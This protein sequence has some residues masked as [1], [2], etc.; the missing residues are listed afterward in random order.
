MKHYRIIISTIRY[1][2]YSGI[3]FSLLYS[4]FTLKLKQNLLTYSYRESI[5]K[6][7]MQS[8]PSYYNRL[9]YNTFI[10]L[11]IYNMIYCTTCMP[12]TQ[13]YS[14]VS[15]F[16]RTL[17]P[18]TEWKIKINFR[19]FSKRQ[20]NLNILN[21]IF[22]LNYFKTSSLV[23]RFFLIF[24]YFEFYYFVLNNKMWRVSRIKIKHIIITCTFGFNAYCT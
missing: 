16:N 8:P 4:D 13:S 5:N 15:G 9:H 17:Y 21:Y 20:Y 2:S 3:M 7:N 10:V 12:I 14:V 11:Y 22:F 19:N 24:S 1:H 23:F 18:P 6:T